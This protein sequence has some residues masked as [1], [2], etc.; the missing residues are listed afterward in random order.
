MNFFRFFWSS[1]WGDDPIWFILIWSNFIAT[2]HD[3]TS[4]GGL[5]REMGPLISGK[6]RLVKY[7]NLARLME[8]ANHELDNWSYIVNGTIKP[9]NIEFLEMQRRFRIVVTWHL[10][11]L[12]FVLFCFVLF[13]CLV[14]Y[15]WLVG[16][17]VGGPPFFK[18]NLQ[19]SRS[20][21]YAE[22]ELSSFGTGWDGTFL[23]LQSW[24]PKGTP[25]M[26]PPQEIRPY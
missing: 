1:T 16:W 15:H 8:K 17:L 14:G 5:V 21:S 18:T 6:S 10:V 12:L 19:V 23:G 20:I 2:S 4:N 25:P 9:S 7:Y 22:V 24:E 26:P 11:L 3:L 13:V